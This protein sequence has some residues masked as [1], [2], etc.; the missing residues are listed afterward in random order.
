FEHLEV[1]DDYAHHPEE[2]KTTV[3]AVKSSFPNDRLITVFQ[4]HTISRTLAF[5]DDFAD[6]LTISDEVVLVKIYQSARE[7]GDRAQE[8]TARLAEKIEEKGKHVKVV[9]NLTE[10]TEWI[11]REKA[12]SEGLVLTMGAGDVRG[13]GEKLL[14]TCKA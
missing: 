1:Y 5:L 14:A 6:A 2:I 12:S 9:E 3:R 7:N 11:Q 4:P 13:V 8:L 10:G